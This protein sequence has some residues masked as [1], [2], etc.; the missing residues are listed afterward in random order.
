MKRVISYSILMITLLTTIFFF[1]R[2]VIHQKKMDQELT[3][4]LEQALLAEKERVV[5]VKTLPVFSSDQI[6]ENQIADPKTYLSRGDQIFLIEEGSFYSLVESKEKNISGFVWKDCIG[7]MPEDGRIPSRVIVID[8][9]GQRKADLKKEPIEPKSD[10][11][12]ERMRE[13]AIGSSTNGKEYE[14][15]LAV[16][17]NLEKELENYNFVVVQIRRSMD[18]SISN[19]ERA[20]LANQIEADVFLQLYGNCAKDLDKKGAETYYAE[21]EET[22]I[23]KN[24]AEFVLTGYTDAI[25]VIPKNIAEKSKEYSAL[26]W[27]KMPAIVLKLGYLSNTEEE[28]YLNDAKMQKVMG[29]GIASGLLTY[30][31]TS[32]KLD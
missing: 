5:F 14:I 21:K 4:R 29:K 12:V 24:L 32:T 23:G 18:V 27:C 16:A 7:K 15:T 6:S 17:K 11:M 10:T 9:G 25:E 8:A 13:G 1:S 20:N 22:D 26:N 19:V 31:A 28:V 30:F 3:V 2:S